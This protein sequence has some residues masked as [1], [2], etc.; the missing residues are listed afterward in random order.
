M[1]AA[2]AIPLALAAGSATAGIVGSKISSNAGKDAASSQGDAAVKAAQIQADSANK[3]GELTAKSAADAL[4]YSRQQS[5]LS[6]DQYNQ[7]QQ[8]LQPYRNLGAFALGQPMSEGPAPLTLPN[9]PGTQ[10]TPNT[11]PAASGQAPSGNLTDPSAWMSLVGNDAELSKWVTQGLGSAAS[12]PGLVDY[13]VGKI[14]GQP[15]ANANE[16]AGSAAYWLQKLQSDPNGGGAGSAATPAKTAGPV[17]L[18]YSPSRVGAAAGNVT[19]P[20]VGILQAPT[21]PYR[22]L[23]QIAGVQ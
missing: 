21:Y 23:S 2:V 8:R 5:Q 4:A 20:T 11:G 3:Q 12:K 13:Y 22:S 1:P 18:N 9:L 16:Q 14:K 17:T 19:T 10:T 15:G 7:Q 6:L